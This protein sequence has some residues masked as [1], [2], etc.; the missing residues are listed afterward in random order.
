MEYSI[1]ELSSWDIFFYYGQNDINLEMQSDL[2]LL[3]LQSDRSLYYDRRES[4]GVAGYEN[5]P[6]DLNLQVNIRYNI[7]NAVAWK[8]GISASGID[9]MPDRRIALS[10]NGISFSKFGGELNVALLFIPYSN[11]NNYKIIN[12]PMAGIK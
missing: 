3:A 11:F 10:Q 4:G 1:D 5:H 6:N 12:V 7:A 2:M 8:N 9:G